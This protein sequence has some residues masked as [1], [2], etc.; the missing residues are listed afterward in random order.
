MPRTDDL[1]IRERK[2]LTPPAHLIREFPAGDKAEQTAAGARL[3][4]HRA[5]GN[6]GH[7]GTQ[8][9]HI[10]DDV[11]GQQDHDFFANFA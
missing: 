11:G 1:R 7:V 6:D 9:K 8:V 2:E 4:L 3:A 10:V 5:G